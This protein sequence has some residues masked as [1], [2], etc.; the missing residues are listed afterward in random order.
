MGLILIGIVTYKEYIRVTKKESAEKVEVE[1]VGEHK[2]IPA[3]Q[4]LDTRAVVA[5]SIL[6]LVFIP[7]LLEVIL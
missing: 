6:Y 4:V 3:K 7:I 2:A 1:I 5:G